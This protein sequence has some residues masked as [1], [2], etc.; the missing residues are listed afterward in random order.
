A[1]RRQPS[2]HEQAGG[3][4]GS[5]ADLRAEAGMARAGLS[6]RFITVSF[7][8]VLPAATN[9]SECLIGVEA[10]MHSPFLLDCT[11]RA[12][13]MGVRQVAT[14]YLRPGRARLPRD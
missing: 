3:I 13:S 2:S 4:D 6:M 10:G 1:D 11:W 14:A 9:C 8:Q 7:G 5:S 12:N